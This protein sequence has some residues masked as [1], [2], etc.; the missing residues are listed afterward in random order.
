[1]VG[2]KGTLCGRYGLR[3]EEAFLLARVEDGPKFWECPVLRALLGVKPDG[4]GSYMWT[5][6]NYET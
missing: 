4:A 5:E 1:M 6:G 2:A 3:D